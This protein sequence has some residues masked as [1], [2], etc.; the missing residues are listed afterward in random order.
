M[1]DT[2]TIE[3]DQELKENMDEILGEV[4]AT[5]RLVIEEIYKDLM[6]KRIMHKEEFIKDMRDILSFYQHQSPRADYYH[7]LRL[8]TDFF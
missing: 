4:N 3:I 5:H 6:F 8:G 1:S 7:S 2:A